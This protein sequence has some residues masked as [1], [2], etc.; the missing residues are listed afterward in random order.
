MQ[1]LAPKSDF[2]Q[3][4]DP[5]HRKMDARPPDWFAW[6]PADARDTCHGVEITRWSQPTRA[7]SSHRHD[8]KRLDLP[9]PRLPQAPEVRATRPFEGRSTARD[10][11]RRPSPGAY[12]TATQ[13]RMAE[14]AASLAVPWPVV[15]FHGSVGPGEKMLRDAA[16]EAQEALTWRRK[17][18]VLP[19]RQLYHGED[20]NRADG[21][22]PLS[23]AGGYA[24]R[25]RVVQPETKGTLRWSRGGTGSSY[26]PARSAAKPHITWRQHELAP[27]KQR[28]AATAPAALGAA[29]GGMARTR[30]D[31]YHRSTA[32][33]V[34][35]DNVTGPPAPRRR[36]P[37]ALRDTATWK[38]ELKDRARR[39]M[40]G[41]PREA[42]LSGTTCPEGARRWVRGPAKP[43]KGAGNEPVPIGSAPR[44]RSGA[45]K[46]AA[47]STCRA[48]QY[49]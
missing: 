30:A 10:A 17:A 13:V 5:D 28:R 40:P 16:I 18:K 8:Y 1:E 48:A 27:A 12:G 2:Y 6:T 38:A 22:P 44:P 25:S 20:E 41:G 46:L 37:H 14:S 23:R 34:A 35:S 31:D 19:E 36:D 39:A 7:T 47:W 43:P 15:T 4:P 32:P 3:P 9:P 21:K 29:P 11:Y 33:W 24:T 26:A 42:M 45:H 49:R